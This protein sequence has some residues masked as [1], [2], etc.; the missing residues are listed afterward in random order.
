MEFT[1]GFGL[2]TFLGQV[3]PNPSPFRLAR[4]VFVPWFLCCSFPNADIRLNRI[5]GVETPGYFQ[6]SL[7]D[8]RLKI[9]FQWLPPETAPTPNKPAQ[10]NRMA[11]PI[12]ATARIISPPR[13][14]P[15]STSRLQV[16]AAPVISRCHPL[17]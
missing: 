6:L 14:A 17:R 3:K 10:I 12:V 5:S 8:W 1:V 4:R 11:T 2:N 16:R 15:E 7:R 13:I 9:L